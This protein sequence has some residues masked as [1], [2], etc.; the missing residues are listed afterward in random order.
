MTAAVKK[1]LKLD[2][3]EV[4]STMDKFVEW[5]ASRPQR[6]YFLRRLSVYCAEKLQ[7]DI[8]GGD[9]RA[10][11]HLRTLTNTAVAIER[12]LFDDSAGVKNDADV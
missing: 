4:C 10:V 12:E 2:D 7:E 5:L 8:R 3:S 11:K 9:F 6:H 1:Q